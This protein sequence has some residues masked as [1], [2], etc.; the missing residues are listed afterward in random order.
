MKK[1][2]LLTCA[3]SHGT[4]LSIFGQLSDKSRDAIA[5]LLLNEAVSDKVFV[6]YKQS[7]LGDGPFRLKPRRY[8]FI[9]PNS[10]FREVYVGISQLLPYTTQTEW[11]IADPLAEKARRLVTLSLPF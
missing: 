5:T 8:T 1:A 3:L 11:G 4:V 7:T 9:S 6:N 2:L 10:T